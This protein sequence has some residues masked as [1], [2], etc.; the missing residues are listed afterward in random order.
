ML[1]NRV[2]GFLVHISS[3]SIHTGYKRLN[4]YASTKGALEAFLKNIA[5]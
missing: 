1:L 3:I 2:Q 4:M 5:R